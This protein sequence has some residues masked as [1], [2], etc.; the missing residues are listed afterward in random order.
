MKKLKKIIIP[1]I[2]VIVIVI[3]YNI[4]INLYV[5]SKEE[6]VPISSEKE[7]KEIYYGESTKE[8]SFIEKLIKLPFSLLVNDK[9]TY[10]SYSKYDDYYIDADV[11][12]AVYPSELNGSNEQISS[13]QS[14]NTKEYSTTNIQVE[15]VDEADITK[16]DGDYIYSLSGNNVIITDV[17]EPEQA[18]I[19]AKISDG[20]SSTVPEDLILYNNNLIVIYQKIKSNFSYYSKYNN[21]NTTYVVIYDISN[22]EKPKKIKNYEIEQPYYTSRCIGGKLY[23]IA[24]GKLREENDN[25]VTYY[26]ENGKK[27]DNGY[28]NIYKIKDLTTDSQTILSMLDLNNIEQSVKVNSYLMDVENAYVSENNI[29]LLDEKYKGYSYSYSYSSPQISDIFGL[30]GIFGVFNREY[31]DDDSDAGYY[32]NIYKFSFL[33]DGSIEFAKKA[34]EKG[35]TINQFSIDEYNENLRMAI[36]NN[37]GSKVVIYNKDM[38]KI[39]ETESLAEGENMYSSRFLGDRAYLVTYKTIDPLYVIDL[40]NPYEPEVLGELKIPGYSTYLHPYDENHIIGIGMQTEEKVN[41]DSYGRVIS[42]TATITGMKMALFDITDVNRPVQMLETIIGDNRTTSAILKN[43][44]ALLFSKE[45]QLLAIPVNNYKEDFKVETTSDEYA[46]IVE[47]YNSYNKEY[48]SEGY[49]VYN[50]NLTEG[51]NLK[52]IITHNKTNSKYSY[53]TNSRL[54]R[55]M[56]IDDNLYTISEDYIKINNIENLEEIKQ[57][58]IK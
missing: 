51:F 37:E 56:Y 31:N 50:I 41:R 53:F 20:T 4:C 14:E 32:T 28:S 46:T 13:T 12:S 26:K 16:T 9:I 38:K 10:N 18:K 30:K 43:H 49:F 2:I 47:K 45:K 17:R 40:S 44:K 5:N 23:V 54:L 35:K 57:V 7:L 15:N 3:T 25:I 52:G 29:Y 33:K 8:M 34:E 1:I 58:E 48:V 36:Y 42:T 24:T 11:K 21:K 6:I 22:K 55:G 27:I 39:G 19:V